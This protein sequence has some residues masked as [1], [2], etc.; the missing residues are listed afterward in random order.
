MANNFTM[1]KWIFMVV[2]VL[3]ALFPA[4]I[5]YAQ[6]V[7][8]QHRIVKNG[9]AR[10]QVTVRG[11]GTP[12]VFIPSLGR[13][14]Q[15][16]DDLSRRVEKS[17]YK[18]ILPEPRGIGSS[19]GPLEG[20]T[21][22]DLASDVAAVIRA[23]NGGPAIVVGHAHGN[24][25]ARAVATDYPR[26]VKQVVLLA[27]GGLVPMSKQT[28]EAFGRVFNPTLPKEERLAAIKLTFFASGHDATVWQGGWYF[29]VAKAQQ[30]ATAAVSIKEWWAG[31]SA[32]ILVL[33]G[34]EDVIAVP[35][36]SA[37]LASEFPNRVR[38]IQIP[39]AG[40]AMLPEQPDLIA[41]AILSNL[42]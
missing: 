3:P 2:L 27:A 10:L 12:I 9:T 1:K 31:G 22:H 13:S 34:T 7:Q 40:H 42:R 38:V 26:L 18:V 23:F 37:K 39:N 24:R 4:R 35:E 32:P 30:A 17:G 28:Q 5:V 6:S 33:Q 29:D 36:N 14:V 8:E 11:R 21:L 20:I 19:T 16:F 41:T 25:V 15:D